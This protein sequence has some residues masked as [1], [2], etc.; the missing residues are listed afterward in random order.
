[1]EAAQQWS[2]EPWYFHICKCNEFHTAIIAW[3]C[4]LSD[5]PPVL[6]WLSPGDGWDV[7]GV[8]V[9]REQLLKIKAQVSIIWAK[10]CILD[11][12]VCVICVDMTT[13]SW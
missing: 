2:G 3:P 9:K 7:V 12:C 4:I 6:W 5:H 13:L 10:G 8:T 1:M 11:E